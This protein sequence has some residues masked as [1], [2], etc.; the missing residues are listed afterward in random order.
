MTDTPQPSPKPARRRACP[1]CG[2]P[3]VAEFRPF[4]SRRCGDLDL[5]KWLVGAYRIPAVE[6]PDGAGEEAGAAGAEETDGAR[7]R[8]RD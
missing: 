3:A 1:E 2:K 8:S 7:D 6:P 4:C 5:G